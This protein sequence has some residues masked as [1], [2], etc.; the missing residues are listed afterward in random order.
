LGGTSITDLT[1]L[2]FFEAAGIDASKT[3]PVSFDGSGPVITAVAGGH[4]LFGNGSVAGVFP[5]MRSG[6]IKVLA[7]TGDK[8]VST[9]PQIP[10]V[11][12][13]GFP[14]VDIRPWFGLSGPQNIPK[15]VLETLDRAAKK[16]VEN[17][18]FI[19]EIEAVA[20]RPWYATPEQARQL[21]MN[22]I[23]NFKGLISGIK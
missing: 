6:D 7:L 14:K 21:V 10:T 22:E 2:Q 3:K 8:R 9:L 1:N 12:E 5:L 23:K 11:K 16:V 17:P 15:E 18:G 4:I 19:K 13:A 20:N